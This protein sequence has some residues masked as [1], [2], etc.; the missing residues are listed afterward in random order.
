L[1]TRGSENDVWQGA[2]KE[3]RFRSDVNER[4][5]GGKKT[6]AGSKTDAEDSGV[7]KR[8]VRQLVCANKSKEKKSGRLPRCDATNVK[9]HVLVLDPKLRKNPESS[10]TIKGIVH[11]R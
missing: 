7:K 1:I 11:Q 2:G 3:K 8:H 10:R 9:W 4:G 5:E 6:A